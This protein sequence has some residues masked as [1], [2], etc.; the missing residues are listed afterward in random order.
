MTQE[1]FSPSENLAW[2]ILLNAGAYVDVTDHTGQTL[3]HHAAKKANSIEFIRALLKRGKVMVDAMS[4]PDVHAM[5]P[6]HYALRHGNA[7]VVM[8]FLHIIEERVTM[9]ASESAHGK[10]DLFAIPKW[11]R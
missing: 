7:S 11:A 6:L 10:S 5:T 2:R 1:N 9:S 3:L 4:L 8:A